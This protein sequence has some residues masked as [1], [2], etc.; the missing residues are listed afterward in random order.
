M[1]CCIESMVYKY[2]RIVYTNNDIHSED[3]K[4]RIKTII[5]KSRISGL[6]EGQGKEAYS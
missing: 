2:W 1:Y 4:R 3:Q 6:M 5:G